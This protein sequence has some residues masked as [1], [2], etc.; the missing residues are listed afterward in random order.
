MEKNG[1]FMAAAVLI[2]LAAVLWLASWAWNVAQA[3]SDIILLFFLSW[4]VAFILDP[5]ADWLEGRG[6]PRGLAVVSIYLGL[7]VILVAAGIIAVPVVVAQL[8]QLGSALPAYA[9]QLPD[10]VGRLQV[11]LTSRGIPVDLSTVYR[12]ENVASQ[13][14]SLGTTIVQNTLT[15]AAGVASVVFN[16]LLI[17]ILSFYLMLDGETIAKQVLALVPKGHKTEATFLADSVS[18]TFGGF[19]RGQLLQALIYAAGTL[20]VMWLAGLGYALVASVAAGL[21]MLI[22]FIGPLIA[23]I[24]PMAIALIQAPA[25]GIAVFL[26]LFIYQQIVVNVLG[27]KIMGEALG[28][29]PLLV[30]LAVLVGIKVAGVWGAFFGVPIMGVLY[31]MA[32]FFYR[33]RKLGE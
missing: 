6:L 10:W 20:L 7:L 31:A 27:T 2:V 13:I 19:L 1:W 16:L 23:L 22:P 9:Q 25:T 11:E 14:Q 8:T 5:M 26:I 15:I 18:K 29:H 24:I 33:T 28:I 12:W 32:V 4:L 21:L 17:L 3:F 30:F